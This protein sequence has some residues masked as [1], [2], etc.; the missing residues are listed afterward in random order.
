MYLVN[1]SIVNK[2]Y[3]CNKLVAKYLIKK[4]LPL[5]GKEDGIFYFVETE[6]LNDILNSAPFYI[7]W[8]V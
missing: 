7:R 8:L 6:E 1:P 5:L 3:M 4:E 2:K